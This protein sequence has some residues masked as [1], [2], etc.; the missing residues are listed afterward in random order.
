MSG[1]VMRMQWKRGVWSGLNV[2]SI[3]FKL[4]GKGAPYDYEISTDQL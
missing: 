3:T 1:V 4:Q 2:I